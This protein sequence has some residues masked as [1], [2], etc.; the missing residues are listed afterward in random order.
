MTVSGDPR[1]PPHLGEK[2][3]E[4]KKTLH[5]VHRESF[6]SRTHYPVR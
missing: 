1:P 3:E 2:K 4:E 6:K 5:V